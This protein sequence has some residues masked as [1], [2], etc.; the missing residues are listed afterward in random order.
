MLAAVRF[1]Y[2]RPCQA[3]FFWITTHSFVLVCWSHSHEILIE[4]CLLVAPSDY[5]FLI[6]DW[7]FRCHEIYYEALNHPNCHGKEVLALLLYCEYQSLKG[8][9]FRN[10]H[11][12]LKAS[13]YAR[14]CNMFLILRGFLRFFVW[15]WCTRNRC[16]ARWQKGGSGIRHADVSG[17]SWGMCQWFIGLIEIQLFEKWYLFCSC[18]LYTWWFVYAHLFD[19]RVHGFHA[20]HSYSM[21]LWHSTG[22]TGNSWTLFTN[23]FTRKFHAV[24]DIPLM[25]SC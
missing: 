6:D 15:K 14:K 22:T 10:N 11:L 7:Y 17:P 4:T 13:P 21:S 9:R 12:S 2:Q 23:S 18:R 8:G 19:M 3:L 5:T 25:S 20:N 1:E 24:S 16:N